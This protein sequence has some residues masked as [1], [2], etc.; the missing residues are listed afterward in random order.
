MADVLRLKSDT[1]TGHVKL[2]QGAPAVPRGTPAESTVAVLRQLAAEQAAKTLTAQI[3]GL[4]RSQL[5]AFGQAVA[6]MDAQ[7]TR[8]APQKGLSR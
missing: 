1:H 6:H 8:L 4:E 2:A 5:K 7:A 3:Q